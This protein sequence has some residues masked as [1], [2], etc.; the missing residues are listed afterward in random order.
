MPRPRDGTV[1][2]KHLSGLGSG[3]FPTHTRHFMLNSPFMM[4]PIEQ[5]SASAKKGISTTPSP[6][7]ASCWLW[8]LSNPLLGC[9]RSL[10][11]QKMSSH[12][13]GRVSESVLL[14]RYKPAAVR[15]EAGQ[16]DCHAPLESWERLSPQLHLHLSSCTCSVD[17]PY[18][19]QKE[20]IL[21]G[22]NQ[23]P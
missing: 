16:Q 7:L 11:W 20:R 18:P 2:R 1:I 17:L 9:L 8:H 19:S 14:K 5:R 22:M 10:N 23:L 13:K 6:L 4:G 15:A 3:F 21:Q 12:G